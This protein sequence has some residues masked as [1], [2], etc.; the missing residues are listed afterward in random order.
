MKDQLIKLALGDASLKRKI[1]LIFQLIGIIL[2]IIGVFSTP[3]L[4]IAGAY[5][6]LSSEMNILAV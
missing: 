2:M 6:A 4:M 5:I 1:L 3:K